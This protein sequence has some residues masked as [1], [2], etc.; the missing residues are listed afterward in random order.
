ML[1][2]LPL[3]FCSQLD[4]VVLRFLKKIHFVSETKIPQT[5]G[6]GWFEELDDIDAVWADAD[7]ELFLL[8][9]LI[10]C[11]EFFVIEPVKDFAE[12]SFK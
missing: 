12:M 10:F 2:F 8:Q 6:L 3:T 7:F 5:G 9:T 4:V 1:Y 11:G